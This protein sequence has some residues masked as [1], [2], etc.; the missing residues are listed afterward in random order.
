MKSSH[1]TD[2][3]RP[4]GEG[5]CREVG[6]LQGQLEDDDDR[7]EVQG[8]KYFLGERV[9]RLILLLYLTLSV[10]LTFLLF[11]STFLMMVAL[12]WGQKPAVRGET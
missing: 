5:D 4:W 8:A 7:H 1:Q 2:P 12:S 11:L 6:V 3:L 9:K 10:C